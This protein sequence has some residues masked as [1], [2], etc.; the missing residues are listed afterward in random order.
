MSTVV[1]ERAVTT[2]TAE[3]LERVESAPPEVTLELIRGRVRELPMTTRGPRHSTA[4]IR[5]GHLLLNW[6]ESQ[7]D[8][9]GVVAGGEARCRIARNPDTM[10]GIDVAYY[11]GVEYVELPDGAKF[12]DGPPVVAVE[13]LSPTDRHEDVIE[14]VRDFLS[15]SVRQV[16]VADPDL[17]SI[18]VHRPDAEERYFAAST[19]LT[20]EP[21]L[22]GFRC[23]VETLFVGKRK[24]ERS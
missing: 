13:V 14:R 20:G 10:I 9:E 19:E 4:I 18:T 21:E 1:E 17:R 16:W 24:A 7:P 6:L 12:F 8:R 22:P 15:A 5:I 11:E 2:T 3:F 23:A